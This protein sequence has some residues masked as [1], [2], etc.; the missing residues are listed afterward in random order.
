MKIL[1]IASQKGGVGKTT[2]AVNLAYSLARRG[3]QTLL[4]DTDPQGG[5]GFSLSRKAR[6]C[7]GFYDALYRGAE[8]APLVLQTRLP[9]LRILPA[10]RPETLFYAPSSADEARRQLLEIQQQLRSPGLDLMVIDSPAGLVG[11][12]VEWLNLSDSVLVP[13][14]AEP[15]GIRS[16]P[17]MLKTLAVLKERGAGFDLAGIVLTMVQDN[18][19]SRRVVRELEELLP[20]D[21]LV[22]VRIP[23]RP[24]FLQA[25][26]AGIPLGLLRKNPPSEALLFDQLAVEVEQRM[27]LKPQPDQEDGVT[28]LM[29]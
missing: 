4:V 11:T 26:E 27:G 8:V 12:T 23:R 5:V 24:I 3:F 29:D 15:L 7:R 25:S 9:E 14:Q 18:R 17:A 19:E 20:P 10:G 2:V 28:R 22:P 13:Q 16:L 6:K 21:L 1:T